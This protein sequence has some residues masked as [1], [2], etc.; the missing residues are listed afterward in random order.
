MPIGVLSSYMQDYG[1]KDVIIY[2][3]VRSKERTRSKKNN[4]KG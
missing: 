1:N 2:S 4:I 3:K